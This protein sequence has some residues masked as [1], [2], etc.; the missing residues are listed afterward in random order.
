MTQIDCIDTEAGIA[1]LLSEWA[2]VWRRCDATPFQ[3][4]DWLLAWW[5]S[6]G[7]DRPRILAARDDGALAG[8]LPLYLRQET[9]C[10]K[11][12]P[13]GIGVSDYLD[14]LAPPA[15]TEIAA[16]LLGAVAEL[17][18]WQACNLPDL[19]PDAVLLPVPGPPGCGEERSRTVPC[20]V[21]ELPEAV[22]ALDTVVPHKTLRDVR[23]AR[24]RAAAVGDV[25]IE[26]A[27]RDTLD[28]ALN[29]LFRLH[30]KRWQSRGEHGV[31]ASPEVQQF[32]RASARA[33][34]RAGLLR[35]Y[36]LRIGGAVAAVYHGFVHGRRAYAYLG[37]FDPELPRLSPGAQVIAHAIA[38]AI[39]EG[40]TEFHFLRGG[41]AYKYAWGA[42]D[43]WNTARSFRR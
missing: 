22:E 33:M 23:Q 17:P 29:D 19:A 31:C 38:G 24:H 7:T 43:R 16:A 36:R 27:D 35:L 34:L 11:L 5:R 39:A 28:D 20:P 18:E 13:L 1:D 10:I 12:L 3:S 8:V 25:S 26:R 30:A 42:V 4:P 21:L 9:D 2:A 40:V 37:G 15:G 6:F 41:E 32:H 14:A